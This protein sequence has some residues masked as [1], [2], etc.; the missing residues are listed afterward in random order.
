VQDVHD[1]V[2]DTG[3]VR[4]GPTVGYMCMTRLSIGVGVGVIFVD[5][6]T[7]RVIMPAFG[8]KRSTVLLSWLWRQTL[9]VF[10]V[11]IIP[12]RILSILGRPTSVSEESR[13]STHS[14]QKP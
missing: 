6:M 4:D 9:G 7:P 5:Q 10:R 13:F 1:D 11:C 3:R 12:S 8:G 14:G 2:S